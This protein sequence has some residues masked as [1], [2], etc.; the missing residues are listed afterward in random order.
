MVTKCSATSKIKYSAHGQMV[1]TFDF[2][3]TCASTS[4]SYINQRKGH[5]VLCY[6]NPIQL[7]FTIV[8][9]IPYK[10]EIAAA[11]PDL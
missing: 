11:I 8:I 6:L 5:L 10:S 1:E 3:T 2:I 9:F 4:D 7:E